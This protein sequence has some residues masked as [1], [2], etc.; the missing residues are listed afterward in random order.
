MSVD[1]LDLPPRRFGARAFATTTGVVVLGAAMAHLVMR[2]GPRPVSVQAEPA[3]FEEPILMEVRVKDAIP[4]MARNFDPDMASRNAGILGLVQQDSGHFLASPYGSSFA[5]G[6]D[7]EDVW[8]GLTGAEIG[9]AY[10][11]GGLGLAR[12][13]APQ[14][15]INPLKNVGRNDPCPCGSGKKFKKCCLQ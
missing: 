1:D 14:P 8:G 9:E 3:E 6:N 7:D 5:V 12:S 4:Q 13:A 11:T 15:L 2:D 10:G